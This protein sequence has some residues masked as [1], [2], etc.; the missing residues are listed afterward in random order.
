MEKEA[1][2]LKKFEI[3]KALI[4]NA[5]RMV[6]FTGAGVS[7]LSGIPDFRSS[8][9][10]YAKRFQDLDVE[11]I[12]N[13]S[14][15][16]K[17]PEIFYSWAKDIWYHLE[18]FKPNIVHTT[19]SK[20][21]QK[22]YMQALYTQNI[23]MLHKKAGSKKLYE[24]HG[25]AEHHHCTNCNSFFTYEQIAPQVKEGKVPI[26]PQCKGVIKP[27]IVFYGENLDSLLLARAY[28]QFTHTDLCLVLG[29]SLQ[30]NP[31]ASFPYYATSNG[32][33]LVL[34]NAQKTNQDGAA[35]LKFSDL[36]QL[37][38]ALSRWTDSIVERK[39]LL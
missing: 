39:P 7:T 4:L 18:D 21:E 38:T 8:S 1:Q 27:D 26:C 9:G 23:D 12:L 20:L 6:V 17:H 24:L 31:A 32:A 5:K 34:V 36:E 16:K 3:L 25:S 29:S 22:G 35:T 28:E 19:L 11:Q 13:I 10:V 15:F 33:P 2:F 14:F 30:V 37:F